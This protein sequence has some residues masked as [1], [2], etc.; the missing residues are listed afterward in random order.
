M[1]VPL[2]ACLAMHAS[3]EFALR[4]VLHAFVDGERE[5]RAGML[6]GIHMR[7]D[8]QMLHVHQDAFGAVLPSKHFVLAALDSQ[9]PLHDRPL[10]RNH[11]K[12]AE[13][14]RGSLSARIVALA[15][16]VKCG[17]RQVQSLQALRLKRIHI[18]LDP[19]KALVIAARPWRAGCREPSDPVSGMCRARPIAICGSSICCGFTE[20]EST[21]R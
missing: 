6:H 7:I 11:A 8:A 15:L 19:Q 4:D 1:A 2:R 9:H 12:A 10:F 20:T 16:G 5:L 21:A 18:M 17:V 14:V 3:L 13:H